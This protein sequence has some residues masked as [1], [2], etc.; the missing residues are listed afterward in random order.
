MLDKGTQL[1]LRRGRRDFAKRDYLYGYTAPV[2]K[3][4]LTGEAEKLSQ[5][6]DSGEIPE[7][8]AGEVV[9]VNLKRCEMQVKSPGHIWMLTDG[10]ADWMIRKTGDSLQILDCAITV[11]NRYPS[12]K[13]VAEWHD[14]PFPTVRSAAQAGK[15]KDERDVI[16]AE[17]EQEAMATIRE[18][19]VKDYRGSTKKRLGIIE[20]MEDQYAS[21][22]Y[23]GNEKVT[24]RDAISAMNLG[25]KIQ[26][27]MTQL[28]QEQNPHLTHIQF[29]IQA[30]IAEQIPKADQEIIDAEPVEFEEIPI[31][32]MK[33]DQSEG[34]E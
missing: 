24:T 6:L 23:A 13:M 8:V 30:G 11:T 16:R 31:C 32:P 18:Q 1:D 14:I 29:M 33:E 21:S 2:L 26:R 25:D 10:E 28:G 5:T 7:S 19:A 4:T 15:W 12:L 17:I 3:Q 27:G 9:C 22:L 34:G 20:E